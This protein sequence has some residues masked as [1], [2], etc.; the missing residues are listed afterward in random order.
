[1]DAERRE[2]LTETT[3]YE[4]SEVEEPVLARWL[5]GGYFHPPA[6]GSAAENYSIAIP[7]PNVTAPFTWATRST[8]R[9]RTRSF[10]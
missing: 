4:P 7:P 1:M 5:E 8:E 2:R 9:S 10:A 3:R 6:E